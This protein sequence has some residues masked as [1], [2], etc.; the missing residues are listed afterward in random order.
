MFELRF[1]L[2][3]DQ[4]FD[5]NSVERYLLNNIH[6][7]K[8]NLVE[9]TADYIINRFNYL[10]KRTG[11]QATFSNWQLESDAIMRVKTDSLLIFPGFTE[12]PLRFTLEFNKPLFFAREIMQVVVKLSV[13]FEFYIFDMQNNDSKEPTILKTSQLIESWEKSNKESSDKQQLSY[14]KRGFADDWWDYM[15]KLDEYQK[16]ASESMY[17]PE[18]FI[19]KHKKT[20][21]FYNA[22]TWADFM[23]V[24]LP[25]CDKVAIIQTQ[26]LYK[27][28]LK[29]LGIYDYSELL[30][31][32]DAYFSD[33]ELF[34]RRFKVLSI[35]DSEN[36]T[37]DCAEILKKLKSH[38]SKK[39]TIINSN[40]F[41]NI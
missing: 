28:K 21:E 36:H 12:T 4:T 22:V 35:E 1:Y 17:V 41:Q 38:K 20:G 11:V 40:N 16:I 26:G 8:P 19:L 2:K 15:Y 14:L 29:D 13:E 37:D 31:A 7:T 39:F 30:L 24:A 9:N 27:I 25:I 18:M 10:N 6:I 5:F 32:F 33:L 3:N 23:P 34:D